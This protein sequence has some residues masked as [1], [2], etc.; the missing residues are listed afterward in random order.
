MRAATLLVLLMVC[1]SDVKAAFNLEL[2]SFRRWGFLLIMDVGRWL[3]V[4]GRHS[5]TGVRARVYRASPGVLSE[6][7]S[8]AKHNCS[9]DECGPVWRFKH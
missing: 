5:R 7:L 1:A 8:G 3:G 9:G 4:V 2:G 6:E